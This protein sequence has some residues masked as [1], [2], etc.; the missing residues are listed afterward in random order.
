VSQTRVNATLLVLAE[1]NYEIRVEGENFYYI[2]DTDI[3][4][5]R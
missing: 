1:G 4:Q 2:K 3:I 5:I